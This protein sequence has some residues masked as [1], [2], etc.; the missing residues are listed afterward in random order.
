MIRN[1]T[2]VGTDQGFKALAPLVFEISAKTY[3][4][5]A[6]RGVKKFENLNL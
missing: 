6:G 5:S 3:F 1:I 2:L 4:G